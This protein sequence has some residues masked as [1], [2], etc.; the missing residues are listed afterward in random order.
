MKTNLKL[1]A[2]GI[3]GL[4]SAIGLMA[5]FLVW[6]SQGD[7]PAEPEAEAPEP[8][9]VPALEQELATITTPAAPVP[10]VEPVEEIPAPPSFEPELTDGP[11]RVRRL[12]VSTGVRGHEPIGATNTIEVGAQRRVYAFVEAVNETDELIALD[13][14]F[15]PAEGESTGHVSLDIPPTR[16]FRTWAYTRHIYTAGS[17]EIVVR[18]PD[19]RVIARRPFEVVD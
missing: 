19:G 4:L 14:T 15:E 3:A 11:I 18:A 7:A 6:A 12:V 1:V 13:V 9:P 5:G 10:V 16:R 8:V 2:G 17:W